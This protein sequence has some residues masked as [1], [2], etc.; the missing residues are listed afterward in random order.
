MATDIDILAFR[1][2]GAV[3]QLLERSTEAMG[4]SLLLPGPDLGVPGGAPDM[5]IGEV[6]EGRARLNKSMRNS[7]L[8]AAA[9]ARFGCCR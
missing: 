7:S 4:A 2:P 8:I 1:F 5:I 6:K 9:L 3:R